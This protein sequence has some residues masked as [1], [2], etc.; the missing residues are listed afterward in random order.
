MLSKAG[1]KNDAMHCALEILQE[2]HSAVQRHLIQQTL[3]RKIIHQAKAH[4]STLEF[5]HGEYR[6][7]TDYSFS[8]NLCSRGL[9]ANFKQGIK[10]QPLCTF[11]SA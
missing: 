1:F 6:N 8:I 2:I 5:M 7:V 10:E 11:K 4:H 3:C 9:G